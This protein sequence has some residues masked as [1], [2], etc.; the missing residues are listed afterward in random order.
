MFDSTLVSVMC[1][2]V[3][4]CLT[5]CDRM[6]CSL[7]GSSFPW[8]FPDK[9][10]GV[11]CHFLLQ[12]I[13]QSQESNLSLLCLLHGRAQSLPLCQW[14]SLAAIQATGCRW[15]RPS[16]HYASRPSVHHIPPLQETSNLLHEAR[17]LWKWNTSYG[18]WEER[19]WV[20]RKFI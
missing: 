5:L 2:H 1:V 20:L 13:F 15:L 9:T 3:Q 18:A 12:E 17:W 11:G 19:N 4:S 8:D 16:L 7:P 6:D 10:T 14:G